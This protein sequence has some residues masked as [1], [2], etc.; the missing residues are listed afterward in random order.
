MRGVSSPP[1]AFYTC[2]GEQHAISRSVHLARL[3]AFYPVCQSCPHRCDSGLLPE[4]VLNTWEATTPGRISQVRFV[5]DG[6]RGRYLND[7]TRIEAQQW[8]M[9]LASWLWDQRPLPGRCDEIDTDQTTARLPAGPVVVVGYDERVSS[10]DLAIGVVTGLRRMGCQVVDLGQT[11]KPVWQFAAGQLAADAGMY[12]TGNGFDAA[13]T[14]FDVLGPHAVP[15][16]DERLWTKWSIAVTQPVSRPTRTPGTLRT[17]SVTADYE[18]TLW[19]HFHAL[20]PF[21]VVCGAT[22]PLMEQLLARIFPHTPC[23]FHLV[24]LS[25]PRDEDLAAV[26]A[27]TLRQAVIETQAD[28][29]L[30]FAVDGQSVTLM[31]E[32]GEVLSPAHWLPWLITRTLVEHSDRN[33]VVTRRAIEQASALALARTVIDGGATEFVTRLNT[34][35]ALC[36]VDDGLRFWWADATPVCD[37]L[38]TLAAI[39]RAASWSGEPLSEQVR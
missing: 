34:D 8:A 36:G 37:A 13:W 7:L 33:A 24:R 30:G 19:Q 39:L 20:R 28:L 35:T 22:S 11:L 5:G 38:V 16:D 9:V 3:A 27:A 21:R 4:S 15:M 26:T 31:D 29:A 32:R 2:P 25:Q 23:Q 17:W 6:L 18:S 12:I 10:P 14:G 1:A